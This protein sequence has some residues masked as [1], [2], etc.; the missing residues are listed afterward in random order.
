MKGLNTEKRIL[1]ISG[2]VTILFL[3]LSWLF[4]VLFGNQVIESMYKGESIEW[5]NSFIENPKNEPLEIYLAEGRQIFLR[6][7]A[8]FLGAEILIVI[9]V[10]LYRTRVIRQFFTAETHPINLAV[11]RIVLFWVLFN[12]VGDASRIVWF[13]QLPP[14]LLFPPWGLEWLPGFLPINETWAAASCKLLM[15]FSFS[16]MIGL[17]TRTSALLTVIFGL[18]ALGI[19]QFYGKVNHYHFLLWFPAILAAS[20]SGDVFSC[21]A[22]FAAWKRA[23]QGVVDPPGRAREY[24]LP[25]RFVWLLMGVIYLFPGIWK[26]SSG[27]EWALSENLKFHM[28]SKW[29]ELGGWT[30]FF[31]VDQYPL[32]YKLGA[33]GAIVFE[34]SFIFLILFPRMRIV[35][36]VGGLVF[37]NVTWIFMRIGFFVLQKF[38]V[39]LFDWNAIFH[40][41]GGWLCKER[42]H[43]VYDGNCKMCRRTIAS[44]R[45]FDIFGRITYVNGLD[46]EAVADSGLSWLESTA[47]MRDMF[48]VV[49]KKSWHGF[50]AYRALAARIPILWPVVPLLYV[51]PIPEIGKAIYRQVADSRTCSIAEGGWR[52]VWSGECHS[53]M[54]SRGVTMVGTVLLSGN[55]LF[56]IARITDAWPFACFPTFH[57]I[58]QAPEKRGLTMT[59]QMLSGDTIPWDGQVLSSQFSSER[60]WGLASHILGT[61]DATLRRNRLKALFRVWERDEKLQ[62]AQSVRFY[63]VTLLTIPERL[64]ENPV[65]RKFLLELQL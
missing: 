28:Y 17:F 56:G 33:V 32:L 40:K 13:S 63:E 19:P 1:V 51:W 12:V 5:L 65:H 55:I 42:M 48:A 58:L 6:F 53:A 60:F 11:F 31:R 22:V 3:F 35:A 37:H 36:A 20:R 47:F 59:L 46:R 44:L 54:R 16:G 45:A 30:P 62:A 49:G 24:A 43:V 2:C 39:A 29:F 15:V 64:T 38:Y 61:E 34:I 52:K 27:V 26:L 21:D 7:V 18:Y 25:L 57:N 41:I 50:A 4:Y 8:L 9:G 14:E 10:L 23:D